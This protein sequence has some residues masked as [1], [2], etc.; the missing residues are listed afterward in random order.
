MTIEMHPQVAEVLRQAQQFQSALEDQQHR[1]DTE[2]FTATD[3]SE[4]VE[5][6]LNARLC[7][8]GLHI[9]DGLLRLGADMV[10]QRINE[11][12]GNAQAAATEAIDAEHERLIE[13]AAGIAGSLKETF[14]LT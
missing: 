10:E 11:A 9:E 2:L 4:S 3:E 1:T 12:I 7:L 13:L 14:D 5:V 6:T 8:T